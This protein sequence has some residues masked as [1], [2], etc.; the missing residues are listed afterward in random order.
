MLEVSVRVQ[1][2]WVKLD[3]WRYGGKYATGSDCRLCLRVRRKPS[4][5]RR[6]KGLVNW[7]DIP[8]GRIFRFSPQTGKHELIYQGELMGGFTIQTDGSLLLF[9]AR[10]FCEVVAGRKTHYCHQRN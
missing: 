5:A 4:L 3:F 10:G 7:C 1:L 6:R 2:L 8:A 9:M